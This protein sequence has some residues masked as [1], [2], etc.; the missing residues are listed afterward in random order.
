MTTKTQASQEQH[1]ESKPV[2][3]RLRRQ[4]QDRIDELRAMTGKNR[5]QIVAEAVQLAH[6]IATAQRDGSTLMLKNP[7]GTCLLIEFVGL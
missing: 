7:D 2:T 3:M 1:A 4:T 6:R 5:T